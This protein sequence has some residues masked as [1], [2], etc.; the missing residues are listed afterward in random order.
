MI[1]SRDN[2]TIKYAAKLISSAKYRKEEKCF[3]AEG[4]RICTDGVLS[5]AEI[6]L[7]LYTAAAKE[8]YPEE[9]GLLASKAKRE[10]E[11]GDKL[12]SKISDTA[13]PQGF[14][15]VFEAPDRSEVFS[16]ELRGGR[17]AALENIQDPSNMGTIIRSAEALGM[18]GIILSGDCCD[19]WSPKV[20]RGSM[21]AIFRLPVMIAEDFTAYIRSLTAKGIHTYASTPHEAE[22]IRNIDFSSGGVMLIGNE[23]NGLKQETI[24]A[25]EKRVRIE[26]K[27]RAESLNAAAA[28]AILL[29]NMQGQ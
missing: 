6:S 12:F 19:I 9:F 4:V 8:K 17:F 14:F 3:A 11:V 10:Y 24:E 16:S 1:T 18:N 28:A 21:G 2:E 13:S 5:G 22:N 15:C 27:G 23:G 25:C 26:M 29:Y 20:V 7:F